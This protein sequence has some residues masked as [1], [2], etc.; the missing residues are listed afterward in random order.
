MRTSLAPT[1]QTILAAV[2]QARVRTLLGY[3]NERTRRRSS[4]LVYF[5]DQLMPSLPSLL[6][7]F[8]AFESNNVRHRNLHARSYYVQQLAARAL[9][10]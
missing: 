1:M 6:L 8:L 3:S 4:A 5:P 9:R 2:L 10:N 7:K